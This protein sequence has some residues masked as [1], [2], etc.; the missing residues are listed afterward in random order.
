M[1]CNHFYPQVTCFPAAYAVLTLHNIFIRVFPWVLP[2]NL[3]YKTGGASSKNSLLVFVGLLAIATSIQHS[4][5]FIT[6]VSTRDFSCPASSRARFWLRL[7]SAAVASPW[8]R[9]IRTYLLPRAAGLGPSLEIEVQ[10]HFLNFESYTGC[11]SDIL[12]VRCRQAR[13]GDVSGLYL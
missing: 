5:A 13:P 8:W 11:C 9:N 4:N 6:I 10:V 7:R 1:V 12:Q 2:P 3:A